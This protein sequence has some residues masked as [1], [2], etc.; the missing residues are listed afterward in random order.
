MCSPFVKKTNIIWLVCSLIARVNWNGYWKHQNGVM[1]C[2]KAE[3]RTGTS[4]VSPEKQLAK[5][6][7]I[8]FRNKLYI[9]MHFKNTIK[10]SWK[11]IDQ[12][13]EREL[14][15]NGLTIPLLHT[16]RVTFGV[17]TLLCV[18][19]PFSQYMDCGG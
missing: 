19:V 3:R 12:Y 9:L 2:I 7:S 17:Q 18:C 5:L 6:N 11:K 13:K 4:H 14:S 10:P 16:T 1:M 15:D 8:A